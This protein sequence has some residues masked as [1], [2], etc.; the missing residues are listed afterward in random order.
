MKSKTTAGVLSI[1][2]G[3]WG[4]HHFYLGNIGKGLGYAIVWV[5]FCWTIAVPVILAII[6]IIEGIA[7]LCKDQTEFDMQYN[8]GHSS[9]YS[10]QQQ[11]IV[12]Q[13]SQVAVQQ[14][15]TTEHETHS[16]SK[17]EQLVELK[18]LLDHGVLTQEEFDSEKQKVLKS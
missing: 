9:V 1:I 8:N 5:L 10:G 4:I 16:K 3:E 15:T 7:L 2:F 11:N 17:A 14:P 18:S 12:T 6:A 13:Q